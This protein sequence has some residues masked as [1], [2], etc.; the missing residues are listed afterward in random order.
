MIATIPEIKT[1]LQITTS[2]YDDLIK[3]LIPI[4]TDEIVKYCNYSFTVYNGI[5]DLEYYDS[6]TL[7]F[8]SATGKIVDSSGSLA[9]LNL[10]V[11]DDF[12]I[13]GS[14]YNDGYF[15]VK[16]KSSSEIEIEDVNSFIDEREGLDIVVKRV[17]FPK[18]LN[19]SFSLMMKF[20]IDKKKGSSLK[21][22]SV[23]SYSFTNTEGYDPI[24]YNGLDKF[25]YIDV[26]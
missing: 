6:E 19:L 5:D 4:L 20:H 16:A 15:T 9:D 12:K 7:S 1:L 22:E 17:M 14:Q 18:A 3:L 25:K 24:I 8:V 11:G 21:S 2:T 13:E 23:G 26:K 10:A